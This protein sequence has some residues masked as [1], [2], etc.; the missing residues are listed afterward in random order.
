MRKES[1]GHYC[2]DEIENL[3]TRT[4]YIVYY[5][6]TGVKNVQQ[7]IEDTMDKAN[8]LLNLGFSPS[9]ILKIVLYG[10]NLESK[11]LCG[12][13]YMLL[14]EYLTFKIFSLKP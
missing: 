7:L 8:R 12:S 9:E 13:F 2:N 1:I 4:N 11:I 6:T 10:D 14:K 3:M 5:D